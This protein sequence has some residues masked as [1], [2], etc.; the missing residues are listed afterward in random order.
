MEVREQARERMPGRGNSR[1]KGLWA[2]AHL[3]PEVNGMSRG[4]WRPCQKSQGTASCR[5]PSIMRTVAVTN[6]GEATRAY[7]QRRAV[8]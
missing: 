8:I 6:R 2:E 1:Y 7:E 5:T 3:S 4:R